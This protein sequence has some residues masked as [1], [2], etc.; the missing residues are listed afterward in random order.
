M[1]NEAGHL[2]HLPAFLVL[3]VMRDPEIQK[4]L[5]FIAQWS[6]QASLGEHPY[7]VLSEMSEILA[8]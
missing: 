8:K 7:A 6:K 3:R 5:K 1:F 4:Y 2:P